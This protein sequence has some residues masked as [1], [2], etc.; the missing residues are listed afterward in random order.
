[1]GSSPF[2]DWLDQHPEIRP[3]EFRDPIFH[4]DVLWDYAKDKRGR[5][6]Y[7]VDWDGTCVVERWP[8]MGDWLPGAVDALRWLLA[9][10]PTVIYS[11]RCSPLSYDA[12]SLRPQKDV[13][14]SFLQIRAMLDFA[15]LRDVQLWPNNLGKPPA[16]YYIDDRGIRFNTW[17]ETLQ[18][19]RAHEDWIGRRGNICSK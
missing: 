1:M 9:D 16:D 15:D 19:L 8:V 6:K 18:V 2:K 14:E 10:G 12:N 11:V 4:E 5:F 17:K 13:R 7:C 3:A